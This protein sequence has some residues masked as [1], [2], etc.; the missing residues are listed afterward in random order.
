VNR[1]SLLYL[2]A[3]INNNVRRMI[4]SNINLYGPFVGRIAL[5]LLFIVSGIGMLVSFPG[6]T[7]YFA[8]FGIP[9]A[10]LVVALVIVIKIGAGLMVATGIHA[11]EGALT[12]AVFTLLTIFVAHLNDLIGALKNIAIIGGLLYVAAHDSG[13]MSLARKCPC[14]KCKKRTSAVCEIPGMCTCGICDEC[15][16]GKDNSSA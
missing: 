6:T 14:P 15:R 4:N 2:D 3:V 16:G 10:A 1:N 13:N 5:S 7:Q 12:L 9:F 8:S 11:R